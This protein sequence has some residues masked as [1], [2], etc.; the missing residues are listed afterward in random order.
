MSDFEDLLGGDPEPVR[1]RRGRPTREEAAARAVA[2]AEREKAEQQKVEG[3][4][5]SA[6]GRR[7]VNAAAT[8]RTAIEERQFHV[9]VSANFFARV[10]R[11]DPMTVSKRLRKVKPCGYAGGGANK[12]ALYDF[13]D[14]VPYLLKPRMDL[15]TYLKTLNA[16][17]LPNSINKSFWEAERIKNKTLIE[18]SEA[19]PTEKVIDVLGSVF[20]LVKDRMP[21][22]YDKM[23]DLGLNIE[24][25]A[26]LQEMFDQFQ[27]DLHDKLVEM[28]KKKQS[29]SR[30]SEI[31]T[32]ERELSFNEDGD[33]A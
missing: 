7:L 11:L 24:Q 27:R 1:R 10:F 26:K 8:G 23:R 14:T 18:T 15:G 19:W 2:D 28:P 3:F 4:Y 30:F 20:M 13:A 17:D 29:Y 16:A 32:G 21:F 31:D 25:Q 22:M 33:D 9:P 6:E 12:R 5:A